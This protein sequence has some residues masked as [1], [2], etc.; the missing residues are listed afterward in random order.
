MT[1][2]LAASL[3]TLHAQLA[4]GKWR[5]HLSYNEL[6]AVVQAGDRIYCSGAGGLF[7]YDLG[8]YTVN[9]VNKTNI[10]NDVGIST[11][12]YDEQ[13]KYLV[14]AYN[15]ANLDLIKDDKVFN[16][17][18]IKRIN[19]GGNKQINSIRFNDRCA[20]LACGFGIV[21]VD[22]TRKEIKETYYLGADGTYMNIN[23]I[24][25]T[26]SLI[27][28]AT[29]NG[30]MTADKHS[31]MLNI[32]S[33]WHL[34]ET[35][36]LAGQVVSKLAVDGSNRVLALAHF[37]TGEVTRLFTDNND[38]NFLPMT[39]GKLRNFK[40]SKGKIVLCHDNKVEVFDEN[41]ISHYRIGD[42][43]WMKMEP[44][45]AE[46]TAD[47]RLWVAH[48]WAS[49]ASVRLDDPS[50]VDLFYP[51]CPA[52][53]NVYR[54]TAFDNDLM[55]APGGHRSTYSG[56]YF[57]ADLYTLSG[58]DWK[59]LSDPDGLL[60][61]VYDILDVAVNPRN[62]K[63]RLAPAWGSGIVEITDG[64]VTNLYNENNTNGALTP[65]TQGSSSGNGS[66]RCSPVLWHT[67]TKA[68]PGLQTPC[69]PTDLL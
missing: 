44:N 57:P 13:T 35:S 10:L 1:I 7:Y 68:T 22:L 39:S 17:S 21:V 33:N 31:R 24:A 42:V 66:S 34:D 61:G 47:G 26:D 45:D 3:A 51:Q 2:L 40:F 55:V 54:L 15:N 25:F 19:I 49:L 50:H 64:K 63:V 43:D 8:D 69:N 6:F 23:D 12:A 41:L 5:D 4:V 65:F 58:N 67:T 29:D 9:R 53:D 38:L 14:V 32:V 36:L 48:R 62:Q 16:I 52:S 37:A 59:T 46:L 27:V 56:V 28:A 18:D 60:N 30:I 20:Y 11:F